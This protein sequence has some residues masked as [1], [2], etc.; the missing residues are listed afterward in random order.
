MSGA[1]NKVKSKLA[2]IFGSLPHHNVAGKWETIHCNITVLVH[3]FIPLHQAMKIPATKATV[4]KEW[5]QKQIRG[6]RSSNT[7]GVKVHFASLM[8]VCHLKNVELESKTPKI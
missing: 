3:K 4:D 6:D 8:D 2:C 1:S 7:K 5:S